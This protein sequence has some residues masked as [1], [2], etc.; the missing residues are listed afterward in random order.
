MRLVGAADRLH[1]NNKNKRN[2]HEKERKENYDLHNNK[3]SIHLRLVSFVFCSSLSFPFLFPSVRIGWT[4]KATTVIN[5][6]WLEALGAL[7]TWRSSALHLSCIPYV[8]G[9]VAAVVNGKTAMQSA[10]FVLSSLSQG[11]WN[12]CLDMLHTICDTFMILL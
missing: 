9:P 12:A 10:C 5:S 3:M 7:G 2:Q 4:L 6:L 8:Q 1:S 11:I